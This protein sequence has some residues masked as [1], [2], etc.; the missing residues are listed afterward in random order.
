L[1]EI[2]KECLKFDCLAPS[3]TSN[4]L[5]PTT[6][7]KQNGNGRQQ[8]SKT[9]KITVSPVSNDSSYS[10]TTMDEKNNNL[11]T[12]TKINK[13][14]SLKKGRRSSND[15]DKNIKKERPIGKNL[16]ILFK[17]SN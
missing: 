10:P 8:Q 17:S 16:I 4:K 11:T 13:T 12:N 3:R 2:G 7:N 14:S 1:D 9:K 15:L 5:L 6:P